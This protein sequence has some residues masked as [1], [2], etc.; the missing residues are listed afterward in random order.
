MSLAAKGEK[1]QHQRA[2][3]VGK[4]QLIANNWESVQTLALETSNVENGCLTN[5]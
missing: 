3:N 1:S 2:S 5:R 4:P